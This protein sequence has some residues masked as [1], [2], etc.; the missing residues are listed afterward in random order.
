[1]GLVWEP[2]TVLERRGEDS[3]V[4]PVRADGYQS[5]FAVYSQAPCRRSDVVL[6]EW[7]EVVRW[8]QEIRLLE[9]RGLLERDGFGDFMV[10]NPEIIGYDV[11]V[12]VGSDHDLV[13]SQIA[14]GYVINDVRRAGI[15]IASKG[16]CSLCGLG[17]ELEIRVLGDGVERHG[18]RPVYEDSALVSYKI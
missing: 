2:P 11:A 12:V 15:E 6:E 5:G 7:Y 1:M 13:M 17:C 3:D 14:S 18:P 8:A 9:S 16:L 10:H 4:V